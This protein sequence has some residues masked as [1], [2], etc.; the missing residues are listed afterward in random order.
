MLLS[1]LRHVTMLDRRK[2][3]AN[4]R[5]LQSHLT[6]GKFKGKTN[7]AQQAVQPERRLARFLSSRLLGRRPVNLVVGRYRARPYLFLS[8]EG[9]NKMNDVIES[10]PLVVDFN[11]GWM[12]YNQ[13]P[14]IDEFQTG[15]DKIIPNDE[16][17]EG[18]YYT[19]T[20]KHYPLKSGEIIVAA[21]NG[22]T[23]YTCVKN[24]TDQTK[25]YEPCMW[26]PY[27]GKYYAVMFS[28]TKLKAE[29]LI[30]RRYRPDAGLLHPDYAYAWNEFTDPEERTQTFLKDFRNEAV[31]P[32][33]TCVWRLDAS[34]YNKCWGTCWNDASGDH[35]KAA[36]SDDT[37]RSRRRQNE[38]QMADGLSAN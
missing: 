32:I 1:N 19:L 23:H 16:R 14:H 12:V 25:Q 34:A 37:Q 5:F 22:D 38:Q 17:E 27:N 8:T 36:H 2:P 35:I 26:Y 20:H 21:F 7:I 30:P 13:Q 28:K 18:V 29:L 15:I 11:I 33:I 31:T 10:S 3:E 9:K 24:V 6:P 4:Q